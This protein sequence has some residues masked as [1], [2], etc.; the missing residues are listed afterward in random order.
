MV[1]MGVQFFQTEL[2]P[3]R[4]ASA[5]TPTFVN[6]LYEFF[7]SWEKQPPSPGGGWELYRVVEL[8]GE[9]LS[10]T[11]LPRLGLDVFEFLRFG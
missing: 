7:F 10:S 9:G 5:R 4:R 3:V 2:K 11:R 6:L 8:V 1:I